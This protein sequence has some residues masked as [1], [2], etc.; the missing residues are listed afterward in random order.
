MK[1]IGLTTCGG[2]KAWWLAHGLASI[3][4]LID[5]MIVSVG[6]PGRDQNYLNSMLKEVDPNGKVVYVF[7]SW[8]NAPYYINP[9]R[10]DI[11]SLNKTAAVNLACTHGA[12]WIIA[13]DCDMICYEQIGP[14]TRD[15]VQKDGNSYRFSL[16]TLSPDLYHTDYLMPWDTNQE[17]ADSQYS[18]LTLF[19]SYPDLYYAG[20][21]H[22][23][24]DR[25]GVHF[26]QTTD[27]RVAL[28]H[29][30]SVT[31]NPIDRV[32]YIFEK[33]YWSQFVHQTA[34]LPD[35]RTGLGFDRVLSHDELCKL[36]EDRLRCRLIADSLVPPNGCI[37]LGSLND[38]RV[39]QAPPLVLQEP[40]LSNP[41][42]FIQAG[43]P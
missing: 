39:P 21:A 37:P 36:A 14:V 32:S 43:L 22:I 35:G 28:A 23:G 11:R 30:W 29:L 16:I 19:R 13:F 9:G 4:N 3:Y 34:K 24:T 8:Q 40:Y 41:I 12:D 17:M 5:E 6:G 38:P 25:A 31:P 27:R 26:P 7:P 2:F 42:K 20:C 10:D 15:L 1:I 18:Y 33:M